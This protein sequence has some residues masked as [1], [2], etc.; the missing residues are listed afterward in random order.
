MKRLKTIRAATDLTLE[1]LA[2]KLGVSHA[3]VQRW[4]TGQRQDKFSQRIYKLAKILKVHPGEIFDELPKGS[5]TLSQK[6]AA[7]IAANLTGERLAAWLATGIQLTDPISQPKPQ[8]K[9]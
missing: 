8:R 6:R 2:D 3:T 5:L 1:E 7:D 9:R 4:E